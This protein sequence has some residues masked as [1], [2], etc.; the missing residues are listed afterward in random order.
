MIGEMLN[1]KEAD[2]SASFTIA[3]LIFL[4]GNPESVFQIGVAIQP[5]T[6]V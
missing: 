6:V 3:Y 1:K 4:F 5:R 2:N